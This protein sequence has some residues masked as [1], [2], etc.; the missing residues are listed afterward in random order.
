MEICQASPLKSM[1]DI[2]GRGRDF[3]FPPELLQTS[4]SEH[5]NVSWAAGSWYKSSLRGQGK[6]NQDEAQWWWVVAGPWLSQAC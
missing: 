4:V 3:F 5:D 6:V 2:L 1:C